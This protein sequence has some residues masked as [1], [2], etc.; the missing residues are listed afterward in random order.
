MCLSRQQTSRRW[1]WDGDEIDH[2]TIVPSSRS[3]PGRENKG[4]Y[5]IDVREF[6]VTEKNAVMRK[7]L[8][9]R[10]ATAS[11]DAKRFNAREV[12]AFDFRA[13]TIVRWVGDYIR[14]TADRP[15]RRQTAPGV[16]QF[17]DETLH[18]KAG[19]CEDRALLLAS[20]LLAS[21]VSAYNIRV[22]LGRMVFRG[23]KKE[24]A[25]FDHVWVVYKREDGDWDVLEPVKMPKRRPRAKSA[26]HSTML[27][28]PFEYEPH[29]LF[30]S[31]HLWRVR[32]T[33]GKTR[34]SRRVRRRAAWKRLDP[35]FAGDVHWSVIDDALAPWG[36]EVVDGVR[37]TFSTPFGIRVD[38]LD[39]PSRYD[40]I[41]HFDNCMIVDGWER[42]QQR[43]QAFVVTKDLKT[44]GNAAH[45]IA[46]FYAHSSYGNF[47]SSAGNSLVPFDPA[48]LD[49]DLDAHLA[50]PAAYD[51]GPFD[52]TSGRFSRG[53]LWGNRPLTDIP[54]VWNGQLVSGRYA[55]SRD[56]HSFFER[57]TWI[58]KRIRERPDFWKCAGVPHHEEMAVDT[59]KGENTLYD[60]ASYAKQFVKRRAAA[61]NHVRAAFKGAWNHD[62]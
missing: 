19:D 57:F 53:S 23:A 17:P 59:A 34:F 6:L 32:A 24:V 28:V 35:A 12:G 10:I 52:L 54:A 7:A 37:R 11:G 33:C 27:S 60:A 49:S 1:N 25:A 56:S 39:F 61:V 43:L 48:W 58:P 36:R 2:D 5:E 40:P 41:D 18:V 4:R 14:Y 15:S 42:V 62:P 3:V 9:E 50:R 26:E 16:W 8:A 22:A 20:L 30:N 47:A 51:V 45:G 13:D 21:G 31:D 29:F 55:H 38:G 46:D 44:F